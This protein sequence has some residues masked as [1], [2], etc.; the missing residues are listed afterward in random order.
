[1]TKQTRR[2]VAIMF[3]DIQGYTALMQQDENRAIQI[4][5]KHR[6]V[7]NKLTEKFHGKILQYYGDG[8]LSIFDSAIDAVN[9]GMKMQ[10]AFQKHPSIPVRIGIHTGDILF[11]DEEIIGDGVNV[12]SRIESIA[13][14]GSVFVSGKVYDEI[15][16]HTA[17]Q[18]QPLQSFTFKN[19]DKPIEVFAITNKGLVIPEPIKP[20][21]EIQKIDPPKVASKSIT[22]SP[23]KRIRWIAGMAL[24]AVLSIAGIFLVQNQKSVTINSIAVLPLVDVSDDPQQ[25]YF[26]DGMTEALIAELSKIGALR[27]ISRTSVM[28]Y[29]DTQKSVPEIAN[30]LKI[31][32]IVEGS[33][34]RAG[35]K[36][37][38]VA[39]LI[40]AFPERHIWAQTFDRD[41]DDVLSLYS[42]VA[43]AIADEI[44][45]AIAPEE[46][47]RIMDRSKVNPEALEAYLQGVYHANNKSGHGLFTSLKYLQSAIEIDST[48]ADAY[49]WLAYT[50]IEIGNF[51]IQSSKE[52]YSKAKEAAEKALT[53]N[54]NLYVAHASL[55][56]VKMVYDFDWESAEREFKKALEINSNST[57]SMEWYAD[58]LFARGKYNESL[59]LLK[60]SIDL[61]PFSTSSIL[62]LGQ[63]YLLNGNYD[64]AIEEIN[65]VIELDPNF[66]MAYIF[67]GNAYAEK[68]MFDKGMEYINKAKNM[69]GGSNYFTAISLGLIYVKSGETEKALNIVKELESVSEQNSVVM[70]WI[71][72]IYAA[73]D[74]K[75]QALSWLN[76]SYEERSSSLFLLNIFRE[77]EN[78][79]SEPKFINL[80]RK[81]GLAEQ[82]D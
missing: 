71:S 26:S 39:Q 25:D 24:I 67:L 2:L 52:T 31:D 19:V 33:V 10:F 76:K 72:V 44:E 38:V 79:K 16:N 75:D 9:C 22:R 74:K 34:I 18:T 12:A 48:F 81:I 1:M 35:N 8:T 78:L 21:K 61:D 46:K 7:F 45:I 64:L 70:I 36:I 37:R 68:G 43:E 42:E 13:I 54:D 20:E 14:P 41:L 65:R 6:A 17:I 47:M 28:Q 50:Y 4:R 5:E 23:K 15:K 62:H 27:V 69:A 58:Y 53:L 3:T 66:M 51:G 30:E 56:M 60:R 80:Q 63:V 49:A 57:L 32:A 59:N 73:L 55:G 40:G 82:F 77:F 29:K 11:S